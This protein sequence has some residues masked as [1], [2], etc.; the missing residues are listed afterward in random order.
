M[1]SPTFASR[2]RDGERQGVGGKPALGF[3]RERLLDRAI[4][5][6][7]RTLLLLN[8]QDYNVPQARERMF[9]IGIRGSGAGAAERD[10]SRRPAV[11]ALRSRDA[12]TFRPAWQ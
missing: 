2:F 12:A 11:C 9:L 7:E 5:G 8:A 6:F 1:S 4:L 10:D 3:R